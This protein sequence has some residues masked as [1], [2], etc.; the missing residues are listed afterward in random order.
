MEFYAVGASAGLKSTTCAVVGVYDGGELAESGKAV[1]ARLKGRLAALLARG[2]FPGRPGESLLL[3]TATPGAPRA[4]LVGLGARKGWNRKAFRRAVTASVQALARTAITDAL[5]TFTQEPVADTDAYYRARYLA[6]GALAATYRV[7]D[8]KTAR[9]PKAPRLGRL[10]FV[11]AER[12]DLK[13]VESGLAHGAGIGQ[14]VALARD[15][16]NLPGN[17]CTPRHLADTARGLARRYKAV[18]TRIL[19]EAAV[20]KLK[21]GAFLSVSRG[22]DEPLRLIV[23]EYRGGKAGAA[24]IALVGK[25]ITFDTGGISLKDPPAMDEMKFDMGGAASVFGAI[26][27]LAALKAPVNVVAIV[28][29]CENMPSGRATKPGDIV[30]SMSGQ[31]IEV[32]NTDA[33][34]RLILCDAITYARRFKPRAVVDV[35]TLTGA[36]VIALG[37]HYTGLMGNDDELIRDLDQAGRRADDRAWHLPIGEEYA[38]QLR[39]NF[40]DLANVG[41]RE[42]GALTAGSFLWKFTDGL[43]WAHLDIAGTAWLSGAQKGATGRPVPLLIDFLLR[44]G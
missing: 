42:G 3:D 34:G 18:K 14:G 43:K 27:S 1:D 2:D 16:A 44:Q 39:S 6:E 26:E 9:K 5:V 36:C 28:P 22:S 32:L 35:A 38:D 15:L 33:E 31:T 19:D 12:G 23:M 21:M 11:V 7:N 8:L 24:P 4:L 41:G 29:A 25:G 17:I 37:A 10:G 40:A 30:K 20:R 13:G